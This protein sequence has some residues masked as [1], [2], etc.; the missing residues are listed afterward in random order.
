MSEK[1][2]NQGCFRS[3]MERSFHNHYSVVR[4][5]GSGGQGQVYLV[6]EKET[7]V[8]YAAKR[9]SLLDWDGEA[10]LLAEVKAL[11]NLNGGHI[12]RF[13]EIFSSRDAFNAS[14]LVMVTEYMEGKSGL[15]CISEGKRFTEEELRSVRS[16]SLEALAEAHSKGIVHR[17]VKPSNIMMT[18]EGK[19]YVTDFGLAKFLGE[20]TRT[21]S[22]DKGSIYYMAPEQV[23]GGVIGPE[24]DYYGLGLTLI[25]LASGRERTDDYRHENPLLQVQ[26]LRHLSSGFRSSLEY[27]VAEDVTVRRRGVGEIVVGK[28]EKEMG[29]N[30][31]TLR[32]SFLV[33]W[34]SL[35][36]SVEGRIGYVM[37][38][39]NGG[40]FL[41]DVVYEMM[42]KG[43]PFLDALHN[44]GVFMNPSFSN[45]INHALL[46]GGGGLLA[47]DYFRGKKQ[48]RLNL[49]KG[50]MEEKAEATRLSVPLG[51]KYVVMPRQS[52]YAKGVQALREECEQDTSSQQPRI[53]LLNGTTVYRPLTF[54]ENI[55]AR[56]EAYKS[57]DKSLFDTWLDSCTGIAYKKGT[58]K[59][60]IIPECSQLIGIERNFKGSFLPVNYSHIDEIQFDSAKGKYNQL[61]TK[62]EMLEHQA[63]RTLVEDKALLRAYADIVF[64]VYAEKYTKTDKLMGFEMRQNTETDELRAV[65][66]DVLGNDSDASGNDFLNYFGRFLRR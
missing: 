20:Q 42:K 51:N 5:L 59:F 2:I 62:E 46:Y 52:T 43:I 56:V 26:K 49:E 41:G 39:S 15:Q 34:H 27:M 8:K 16:Q 44:N 18:A 48:K 13:K 11:G 54:A 55:R 23:N 32:D 10:K 14:E 3:L 40:Y 19:V 6:E 1:F 25:A 61:L 66:V 12:P 65:F 38:A 24:T 37:I 28:E 17:D 30:E 36:N 45:I 50:K 58:T 35:S 21:N 63:W 31:L 47:Y 22:I 60:K 4:P 7:G 57:W 53:T 64:A 29:V 33:F 9:I